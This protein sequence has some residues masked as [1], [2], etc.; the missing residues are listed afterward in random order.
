MSRMTD[1]PDAMSKE[2]EESLAVILAK[3]GLQQHF[4]AFLGEKVCLGL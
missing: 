2:Q 3:T 1:S 4:P